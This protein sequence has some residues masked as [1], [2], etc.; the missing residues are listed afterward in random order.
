MRIL[1]SSLKLWPAKS[2]RYEVSMR[3]ITCRQDKKAP[4]NYVQMM[5]VLSSDPLANLLPSELYESD[6][7]TFLW[8]DRWERKYINTRTKIFFMI[9]LFFYL[10]VYMCTQ[11]GCGW[12]FIFTLQSIDESSIAVVYQHFITCS[13]DKLTA[14]VRV[15]TCR[16]DAEENWNGNCVSDEIHFN[17]TA[18]SSNLQVNSP[19]F[20][21]ESWTEIE[22]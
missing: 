5:T 22:T 17:F 3:S 8:P 18:F 9:F 6:V 2:Q 20:P 1:Q 16:V 4:Y 21:F 12:L 14:G 15:K 7:T 11:H 13:N 10:F 19:V